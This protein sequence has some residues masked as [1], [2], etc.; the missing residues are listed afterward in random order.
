MAVG[1]A[2]HEEDRAARTEGSRC[3]TE[4]GQAACASAEVERV[5][6]WRFG[7]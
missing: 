2:V 4:H 1:T 5:V 7:G 6:R 3:R